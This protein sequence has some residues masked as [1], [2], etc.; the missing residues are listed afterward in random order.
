MA[1]PDVWSPRF[2]VFCAV[3]FELLNMATDLIRLRSDSYLWLVIQLLTLATFVVLALI[4]KLAF[5]ASPKKKTTA[6]IGNFM[7]MA[8]FGGI[9][10]LLVAYLAQALGLDPNASLLIRAAG[11]FVMGAAILLTYGLAFSN[12]PTQKAAVTQLARLRNELKSYVENSRQLVQDEFEAQAAQIRATLAPKLDYVQALMQ[13]RNSSQDSVRL[14]RYLVQSDVRPMSSALARKQ[15][16]VLID[17]TESIVTNNVAIG[18][19]YSL[20]KSLYPFMF[21]ILVGGAI[22][23]FDDVSVEVSEPVGFIVSALAALLL[24]GLRIL[25]RQSKPMNDKKIILALVLVC[26]LQFGFGALLFV[27]I[28]EHHLGAMLGYYAIGIVAAVYLTASYSIQNQ[29]RVQLHRDL[30]L[31]NQKLQQEI[32]KLRQALWLSRRQLISQL[33]GTV[34]GAITAAVTRLSSSQPNDASALELAQQDLD[35]AVAA[36]QLQPTYDLDIVAALNDL[37]TSWEGV[38]EF[39]WELTASDLALIDSAPETAYYVAAI[40]K[41]AVSN[42]V[43]HGGAKK[44]RLC[45]YPLLD[46]QLGLQILNDGALPNAEMQSGTGAKVLSEL[47]TSWRFL[48]CCGET[49]LD[50]KLPLAGAEWTDQPHLREFL[51][52]GGGADFA[53]A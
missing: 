40:A 26:F 23:L 6:L 16:Q 12:H 45:A 3:L 34:Q 30:E 18:A 13:Q 27:M 35:R 47:T 31:T 53:E 43:R 10:N 28:G 49:L 44:A 11:G 39:T 24:L 37:A 38:C 17:Q 33:H 5:F 25:T 52:R 21:F 8:L 2:F 29:Y 1:R 32:T 7:A 9:H 51:T 14:L 41:E 46:G 48:D 50:M 22:A 4:F 15:S 20:S 36:L 19:K 42:A